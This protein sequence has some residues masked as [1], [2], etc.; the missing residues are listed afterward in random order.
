[1]KPLTTAVRDQYF[2]N[3]FAE[4]WVDNGVLYFIYKNN[5]K[6]NLEAA[7]QIVSDRIKMQKGVSYP[8]FCDMRG[9][10]ET[11][12][13]ARDYLAKEGSTLVKAVGVLIESPVTRI[14]ANFYMSINQPTTP[15]RMFTDKS[16][17]LEYLYVHRNP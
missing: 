11:D 9:I 10:K 16:Q 8:V 13:A 14:M 2:E 15:T 3:E 5:V 1:M 6:I 4:F 12:K 7:K 17:A